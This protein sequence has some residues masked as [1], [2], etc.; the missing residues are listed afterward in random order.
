MLL[1]ILIIISKL[2]IKQYVPYLKNRE[3]P[4]GVEVVAEVGLWSSRQSVL[5]VNNRLFAA[6]GR[7]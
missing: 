1:L 2:L 6:F 3:A 5:L 7:S 4:Q